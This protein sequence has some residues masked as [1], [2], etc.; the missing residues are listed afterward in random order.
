MV[1]ETHR[2]CRK[3]CLLRK[4]VIPGIKRLIREFRGNNH[5]SCSEICLNCFLQLHFQKPSLHT[6]LVRPTAENSVLTKHAE[7]PT[8]SCCCVLWVRLRFHCKSSLARGRPGQ[9]GAVYSQHSV[10]P[11][12][13][14]NV[15]CTNSSPLGKKN[16]VTGGTRL[17]RVP[18]CSSQIPVAVHVH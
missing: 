1:E 18:G 10:Y 3:H 16:A 9:P 11:V 6:G 15:P 5:F 12:V 14:G 8:T 4:S 17:L 13:G 7:S 2:L